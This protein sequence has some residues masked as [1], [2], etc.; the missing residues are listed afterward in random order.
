ME[1]LLEHC[2]GM[3]V[4]QE[5]IVVCALN[6]DAEGNVQSEIRTFERATHQ[7]RSGPQDGCLRCGMD[8]QATSGRFD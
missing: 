8:R 4:H 6:T 3:D 5:T 1:V 2:A 7:E